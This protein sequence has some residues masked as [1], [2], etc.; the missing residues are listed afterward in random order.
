MPEYTITV[1]EYESGLTQ[2]AIEQIMEGKFRGQN[3]SITV[4]EESSDVSVSR[5]GEYV[6][7]YHDDTLIVSISEEYNE[8]L[9]FEPDKEEPVMN[10]AL[11]DM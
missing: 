1:E 10:I 6:N 4:T 2:E 7:I 5:S 9:V 8:M 3:V 11:S